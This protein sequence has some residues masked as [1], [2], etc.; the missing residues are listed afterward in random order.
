MKHVLSVEKL[1]AGDIKALLAAA[2]DA[3]AA[4]AA[5]ARAIDLQTDP[6]V[7]RFLECQRAALRV[8]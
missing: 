5:Y 1:A 6:A 7:Q 3:G 2:G 4:H 8:R